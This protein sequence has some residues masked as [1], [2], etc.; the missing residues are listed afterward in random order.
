MSEKDKTEEFKDIVEERIESV[1]ISHP[2]MPK[3]ISAPEEEDIPK[4]PYVPESK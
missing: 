3:I 2:P 4:T 1:K